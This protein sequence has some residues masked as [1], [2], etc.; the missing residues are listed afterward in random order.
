V[1]SLLKSRLERLKWHVAPEDGERQIME[2][3]FIS[4]EEGV[5]STLVVTLGPTIPSKSG[6]FGRR[7][8]TRNNVRIVRK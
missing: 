6:K 1:N 3:Q 5:T 7:R 4:P 8:R 2:I